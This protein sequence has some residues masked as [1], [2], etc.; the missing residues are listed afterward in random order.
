[1]KYRTKFVDG[2][3]YIFSPYTGKWCKITTKPDPEAKPTARTR[4]RA[5]NPRTMILLQSA[6]AAAKAARS[7][8]MFVWLW[9]Q[10]EVWRTKNAVVSMTNNELKFYGINRE[11]KRQ[12][13]LDFKTAGLITIEWKGRRAVTVTLV[14]PDYLHIPVCGSS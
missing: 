11:A 4:R 2:V 1:M 8:K 7:P 10:Y 6:A 12:A 3:E 9:L 5:D 13:L 14:D